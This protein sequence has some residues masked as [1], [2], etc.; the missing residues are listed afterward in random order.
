MG[1]AGGYVRINEIK[2]GLRRFAG[3]IIHMKKLLAV[4][5]I[6]FSIAVSAQTDTVIN[7]KHYKIVDEKT[8]SPAAG[9]KHLAPLDSEFVINN[10]KLK[11]YNNWLTVGAGGQQNLSYKYGVGFTGGLDYNFHIKR[12]Y[13]QL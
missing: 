2:K 3:T 1:E 10:K 6:F 9:E 12:H 13:Y 7:G 8:K 11:Y 5:L 4:L